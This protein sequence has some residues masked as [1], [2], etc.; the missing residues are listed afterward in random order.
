M[1]PTAT[2]PAAFQA[3]GPNTAN[4]S[5]AALL[6]RELLERYAGGAEIARD[7]RNGV[8]DVRD[9][10]RISDEHERRKRD[11]RTT[12][13]DAVDGACAEA[14]RQEQHHVRK[15]KVHRSPQASEE[16]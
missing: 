12:T 9:D 6:V 8:A 13:G 16:S 5:A 1:L 3:T 15:V 10:S 2:S 4:Q 14:C 7:Q 11:Q